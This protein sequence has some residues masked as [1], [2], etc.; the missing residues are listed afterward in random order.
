[1]KGKQN[2]WLYKV[3]KKKFKKP[4]SFTF[5]FVYRISNHGIEENYISRVPKEKSR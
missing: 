4:L 3:I 2:L 1:M 5:N